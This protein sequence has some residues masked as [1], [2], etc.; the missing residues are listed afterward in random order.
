MLSRW[1]D[2]LAKHGEFERAGRV[3]GGGELGGLFIVRAADD[4]TSAWGAG[5]TGSPIIRLAGSDVQSTVLLMPV[6]RWSDGTP[7][8]PPDLELPK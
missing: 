6:R 7:A 2:S 5:G 8:V 1:A 4:A 3:I